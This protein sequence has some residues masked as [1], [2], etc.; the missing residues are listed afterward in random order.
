[1]KR[2]ALALVLLVSLAAPAW[3]G[4]DEG[5]AAYQRGDYATAIREW[6]PLAEQGYP[7]AQLALGESYALGEGVRQDFVQAY[8]WFSLAAVHGEPA[9]LKFRDMVARK[10]TPAQIAEAEKLAREWKPKKE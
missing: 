7:P 10:M 5:W 9:I 3:T 1:M 2:I 8:L 4:F 6:R